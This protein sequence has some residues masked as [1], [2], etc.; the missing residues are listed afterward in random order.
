MKGKQVFYSAGKHAR[1][2]DGIEKVTGKALYTG[3]LQLPGMAYAKIL[4]SPVAHA[5]LVKVDASKAKQLTGV[6][7]TLTRDDIKDFNYKYGATYKDQSIVAVDKVRYVGDPVAAVVAEDPALAEQAL[8]LIEVEYDE[9]PKVTNIEEAIAPGAAQVH[10]GDVARA[11]LRGSVYGAPERFRGTNICYYL[12]FSKGDVSKGFAAS[13]FVFEDTFR[14][15]KVQHYSLEAHINIAHYDGDKLTVWAS[16]QDPFTLRDHLAGIF[17]LPLSRVRVIVPWVGGGYGGKLYVKAEPI[18]VALSWKTRRPVKLALSV[19]ESFKTVTR[20]PARVTIKTGVSKDGRLLARECQVYMDTGAY[21]DAGPRVTQKAGYRA[22]GPYSVPCA[23]VEAHGVYTNTVPAGAFRGFGALQV[24]WA[25][26]SQMDMIAERLGIDPLDFRL[27]NLL[28]KGDLYTAGDTPVD[29]DLREGLLRVADAIKWKQKSAKPNTA[30]GI[31]CCMKD[32]GGTY[33]V[34]GATVKMSSDGSVVLLTGTV[35]VGQGPRTALSQ[36]VAEELAMNLDQISVAQLDT[37]VTPY[38]IS[39]SASSS[40]VVMGTAVQRAAQDAKRQLLQC[41]AKVLK[42]KP[43]RL[44]IAD[45]KVYTR[46]GEATS[47]GKV[48]VDFFGSKAGEIIG[49]GLYKDK[50][51][52]KAIL[53]STTTFWEVGWGAVEVEVDPETGVIR[54]LNYVS[55]ADAGKAINP[56]QCIGQDE[57]AVMF[58]IGHTLMEEMVYEDGQLLNPNLVDYRV[59]SFQDLPQHLHTILIENGNG[60]GPFGSK[61]LGEGG[62]LPVASAVANAVSRAVGVRIQDLPLTPVKVWQAIQ[63]KQKARP[64][65]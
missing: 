65:A 1:R 27:K 57:G 49:R 19:N 55:A 17:R 15:Q 62:L 23:K 5:R 56:D 12:G 47:Y 53:G 60:P 24:T 8:D 58:G 4:R 31:S 39:T 7:G 50:R 32:A 13:D 6:I 38:D 54:L 46:A 41:A 64:V 29:C 37:D 61:G 43:D 42:Q 3:D 21:A 22:L 48:I 20:H 35:E 28:K 63:A 18:A 59:P 45:G 11:E 14:F 34:A 9:L 36:V 2:V 26:E 25:Y 52:D 40:M 51:S 30:K 16:C 10:E 33:K 44:R